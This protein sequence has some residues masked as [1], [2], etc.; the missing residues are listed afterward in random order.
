[1][2]L[3]IISNVQLDMKAPNTVIVYANQ[4]DSAGSVRAQ[5]LNSGGG[6]SRCESRRDVQEIR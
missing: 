1:M 6:S 2:A 5:L 4:Y 3:N